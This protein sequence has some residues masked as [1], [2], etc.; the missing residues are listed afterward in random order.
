M[1][2]SFFHIFFSLIFLFGRSHSSFSQSKHTIWDEVKSLPF[3]SNPATIEGFPINKTLEVSIKQLS[4]GFRLVL[5]DPSYKIEFFQLALDCKDCD[6]GLWWISGDSLTLKNA[7][8]LGHLHPGD[9]LFFSYFRIE[10]G[11]KCY[12][13]PDFAVFVRE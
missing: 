7:P 8:V 6:I 4:K 11:G 10:K 5:W 1:R 2:Y 3:Y 12:K 9:V 13:T